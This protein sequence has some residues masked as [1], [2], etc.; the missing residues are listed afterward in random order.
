MAGTVWTSGFASQQDASWLAVPGQLA[1][2][3]VPATPVGHSVATG[4]NGACSLYACDLD[5]DGDT[6]IV[7]AAHG[8]G[9]TAWWSNEGGDPVQWTKQV[10]ETGKVSQIAV[11][12][13]DL[14]QDGDLDVLGAN[15]LLGDLAWWSNEGGSPLTW[16]KRLVTDNFPQIHHV[17]TG[18]MDGDGDPDIVGCSQ[19]GNSVAW[20]RNEGGTPPVWSGTLTIDAGFGMA[21][22]V[23]VSDFDLDGDLD[24][25]SASLT[26]PGRISWW[27]NGGGDP[28]V[29]T[30]QDIATSFAQAHWVDVGDLDNDGDVDVLGAAYLADDVAWWRN[31]GGDPIVWTKQNIDTNF[32]GV[33]SAAAADMDGDGDLDVLAAA[34]FARGLTWWQNDDGAGTVWVKHVISSTFGDAWA[35]LATDVDGD[36]DLDAV[37]TAENSGLVNWWEV[38]S[39]APAGTLTSSV[40]DTETP[41]WSGYWDRDAY[42]PAGG[43]VGMRVR[44]GTDPLALG[45]WSMEATEPG[46]LPDPLSRYV[47]YELNFTRGPGPESPLLRSVTLGVAEPSNVFPRQRGLKLQLLPSHPN[48]FNPR[49]VISYDVFQTMHVSLEV[50]DLRGHEVVKLFDGNREPGRYEVT[51]NGSGL[52][53]G[54]YLVRLEGGAQTQV[55]KI[56]LVE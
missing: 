32:N 38:T 42:C 40:L 14:D 29:W 20:W 53:S 7:G 8:S 18:D 15:Y 55:N 13:C 23:A 36:G 56:L 12:V 6:D 47:Q 3:S 41:S 52:A 19:E 51:L 35:C 54:A 27:S 4:F 34:E 39:F 5:A 25:T 24:V 11:H 1:L 33:L 17:A 30:R 49:T 46:L 48:P 9:Q 50:Y 31:E 44:S 26:I 28:I 2:A 21:S 22:A 16:T 10:L 37:G 43:T 45:P